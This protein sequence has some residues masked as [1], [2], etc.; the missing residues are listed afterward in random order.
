MTTLNLAAYYEDELVSELSVRGTN[1]E[2]ETELENDKTAK[3]FVERYEKF[4][5]IDKDYSH[6]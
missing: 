5:H 2:T 3:D 1:N 6:D 4:A